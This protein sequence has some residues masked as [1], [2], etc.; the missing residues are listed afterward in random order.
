MFWVIVTIQNKETPSKE[1]VE[2]LNDKQVDDAVENS[3]KK[4]EV[5][6]ECADE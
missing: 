1:T 3:N 5:N 4:Q 6:D 2:E